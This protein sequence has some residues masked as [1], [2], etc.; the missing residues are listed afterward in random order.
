MDDDGRIRE[1][2]K[3]GGNGITPCKDTHTLFVHHKVHMTRGVIEPR[4][5]NTEV[6]TLSLATAA[7]DFVYCSKYFS[8]LQRRT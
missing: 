2:M 3:V 5:P 4:I 1:M 6:S 8:M 7:L